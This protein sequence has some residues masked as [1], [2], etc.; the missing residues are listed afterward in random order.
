MM[1]LRLLLLA[2]VFLSTAACSVGHEA[3]GLLPRDAGHAAHHPP[4][5]FDVFQTRVVMKHESGG[6]QLSAVFRVDGDRMLGALRGYDTL[7]VLSRQR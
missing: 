6:S 7:I 1:K 4:V 2:G 3:P 5:V